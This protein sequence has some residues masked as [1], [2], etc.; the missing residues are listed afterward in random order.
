MMPKKYSYGPRRCIRCGCDLEGDEHW[1]KCKRCQKDYDEIC[2]LVYIQKQPYSD[3]SLPEE[4]AEFSDHFGQD[5]EL[6]VALEGLKGEMARASLDEDLK[7]LGEA[8]R[9]RELEE[10]RRN[11]EQRKH[12]FCERARERIM[13]QIQRERRERE[14]LEQ[15]QRLQ[16]ALDTYNPQF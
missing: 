1:R 2:N 13:Q 8:E 10:V 4:L 3:L 7:K 15:Q 16:T 11:I 12:Y 14:R 5:Y 9:A 6:W